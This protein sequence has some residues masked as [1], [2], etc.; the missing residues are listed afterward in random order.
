MRFARTY[1][2]Q[3]LYLSPE[4]ISIEADL[5]RGIHSFSIVGL[6]D[7][8]VEEARD[9]VSAAIKNSGFPSPKQSAT[10]VTISLAPADTKKEGPVFDLAIALAYL[11]AA[12]EIAFQ[13]EGKLFLGEL[14]L[15]GSLR[16][17][18]GV[19]AAARFAREAGFKELYVPSENAHEA[20]LVEGVQIFGV[21]SLRELIEHLAEKP[22]KIKEPHPV[23]RFSDGVRRRMTVDFGDV[24]AQDAA[25]RGLTIAAAGRHNIALYGPPGT[26]KTMLA[27]AFAGILPPLALEEALEV[28]EIHSL[29]GTLEGVYIA[30]PPFRAPHHSASYVSLV[31]GG[32]IVRPGEVTLAH[33]GVLFLDEFPEFERRAIDT[34]R[35]PLENKKVTVS[36]A[37]GSVTFPANFIL[38]AAMNPSR[39][40][41]P[42]SQE[43]ERERE[44]LLKK[45]SGPIIDRIDMWIEVAHVPHELLREK[46]EGK[47]ESAEIA[48]RVARARALQHR[49]FSSPAK[50]NSD[51]GVRDIEKHALLQEEAE[52]VL[53][54]AAKTLALSPRSYHRVIKLARTIADLAE[55][56]NV[57][58]AHIL[59]AL[60]Y[61][62]RGLFG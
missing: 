38:I 44:R 36:R 54:H 62:P 5:S 27:E 2:V 3:P 49:R 13:P 35:E 31:G 52:R 59:E 43:D 60:Q 40:A 12:E 11:L 32:A 28:T 20:A 47:Q 7:K 61:R 39:A 24:R 46:R 21:S 4:R 1:S 15:D 19:L 26:G 30:E 57:E 18:R 42:H 9:R 17:I 34:L 56:E 48:E 29:A 23:T 58:E 14:A 50:T 10:K 6:P 53:I 25:K 55:S 37:K 41:G 45:I 8:A 51:M 33:R 16:P 22:G